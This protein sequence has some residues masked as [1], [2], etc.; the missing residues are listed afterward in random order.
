MALV[1]VIAIAA[2]AFWFLMSRAR[3]DSR[4]NVLLITIDTLRADHVGSY[5]YAAARTPAL[6]ALA[7]RGMRFTQA[8]TVAPLT[9]PAHSSLMTGTFPAYNG[10]RDNGGFY[11][12]DDQVTL[13][14]VVRSHG[15]RTGGF[16]S[17]FVLDHRWGIGRGFDRY[18]DD[19]DLSKYRLDIGLD[20]VQRPGRE[21]V[22]KA[23]EW[24]DQ[25]ASRPFLAWVHLYEPHA[26]YDPPEAM[27][28]RFPPTMVG[29]YDA[30]IATADEQVGRLIDHLRATGRLDRTVVV[31]LGDHGE[32]LGEHGEEQHG[33]F[34]YDATIRIPL[35]VAGPGLPARI[36]GDQVRIVD[37][38]PTVLDLLGIGTPGAV[39][40]R[41]LVPL[42]RGGHLDLVALSETWYPR[43]HYGWSELT[44]I[45]DGRYHFIAAPRRELYDT[46]TDPGELHNLADA[47]AT[48]AD[49]QEQALRE[50]LARASAGHAATRPRAVDPDVEQRLRAL[51]Y[52]ASSISP[53]ALEERRRGDP[54]DKIGLYNLLKQAGL[55]SVEG[56]IDEGI[57]KVRQALAADPEIVEAYLML[58]NMN[59]KAKRQNESIAAYR[60]A[61]ELDPD[62][63]SAAFDLALAYKDAGRTDAAEAGFNRVLELD[64]RD[65]KARYRLAEIWMERGEVQRAETALQ[66]AIADNVERPTFLTKL[67]EC[68]IELKKYDAAERNLRDALAEKSD[69]PMAHYDLGLVQEARGNAVNAIAEYEA[70]IARNPQT[71]RAQFNLAKLLTASGRTAE[72]ARHFEEAVAANPEFGTGYLYLAKARLDI[73]DLDGAETA[74]AKGLALKPDRDMAPLGHYVLADLYSRRGRSQ[75]AAR[76]A[77][78]GR[79]EEAQL[80]GRGGA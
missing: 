4:P 69:A 64:P 74:A 46:L 67:A 13:A 6:D 22:S 62:N 27:R 3:R 18:F 20:A 26:P 54:K 41:S 63:E 77:A 14:S 10:V 39:Q 78:E 21:V 55:D 12:G 25:D 7:A 59:A 72:A 66:R 43:H 49:V 1:G 48:R 19:F 30:E 33:F 56:R 35:I 61:L 24:L 16:I 45:R 70:E 80:K 2:S 75:D 38:M 53:R 52:V 9:L 79:R 32:S 23:I 34:V 44:S 42:A 47:N 68:D 15:Y 73:G 50:M 11:L 76:E 57:G 40:G 8:A 60:K 71:Y 58:G 65:P 36:V 29:A 37:V 28:V 31:V 5:G 17:A 51:G